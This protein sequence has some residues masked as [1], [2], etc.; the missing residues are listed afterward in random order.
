MSG[1]CESID[2]A[3]I[4]FLST[5]SQLLLEVLIMVVNS[6][7]SFCGMHLHILQ[8]VQRSRE[9]L[10]NSLS[11]KYRQNASVRVQVP[12]IAVHRVRHRW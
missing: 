12:L 6:M 2:F 1:L 11:S 5:L 7:A 4:V 3:V 8:S 10:S 9:Q